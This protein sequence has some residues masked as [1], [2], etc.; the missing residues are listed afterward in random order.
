M[1]V[2]AVNGQKSERYR[3]AEKLIH[4]IVDCAPDSLKDKFQSILRIYP[5]ATTE[6]PY[7]RVKYRIDNIQKS[8]RKANQAVQK[9]GASVE[10]VSAAFLELASVKKGHVENMLQAVHGA[11]TAPVVLNQPH[12]S[13]STLV[14]YRVERQEKLYFYSVWLCGLRSR[15]QCLRTFYRRSVDVVTATST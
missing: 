11:K 14:T 12:S 2:I 8:W 3:A 15:L 13:D 4:L 6:Q 7:I 10:S 5:S 9:S 1:K